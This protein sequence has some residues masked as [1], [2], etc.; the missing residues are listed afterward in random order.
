MRPDRARRP[1]PEGRV[2]RG[3]ALRL[4]IPCIGQFIASSEFLQR[5][6]S[7]GGR[8]DHAPTLGGGRVLGGGLC[9]ARGWALP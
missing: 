6:C 4:E 5:A 8:A 7:C 1:S 3:E 9:G 2:L